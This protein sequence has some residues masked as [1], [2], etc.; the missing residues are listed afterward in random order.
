MDNILYWNLLVIILARYLMK[1][2]HQY[3]ATDDFKKFIE[4]WEEFRSELPI[5]HT[6]FKKWLT[7]LLLTHID[8]HIEN[9]TNLIVLGM[10]ESLVLKDDRV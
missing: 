5:P 1:D 3:W 2:M 8:K 10:E 4:E 6:P 9:A 7:K